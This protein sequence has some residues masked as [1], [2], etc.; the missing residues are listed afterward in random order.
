MASFLPFFLCILIFKFLK[1]Q[2]QPFL[3]FTIYYIMI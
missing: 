2:Q 3:L 1:G